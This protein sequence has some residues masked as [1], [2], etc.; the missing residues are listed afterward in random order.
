MVESFELLLVLLELVLAGEFIGV[1]SAE[2][3]SAL[4][5]RDLLFT[6]LELELEVFKFLV[7]DRAG[8]FDFAQSF[9]EVIG[10]LF[11]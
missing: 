1:D 3:E 7:V 5:S 9:F 11:G 10:S 8:V 2:V 6:I 4:E